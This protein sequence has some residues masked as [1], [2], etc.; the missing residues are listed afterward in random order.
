MALSVEDVRW[1]AHLSRLELP[2]IDLER[3]AEQL[4]AIIDYVNLLQEV[5]T[6]G[7]EPMAHPLP[8]QNVFRDDVLAA[9]LPTDT[10]LANAPDRHGDFYSRT[11]ALTSIAG[12]ARLPQVTIPL[13]DVSGV[14]VGLSLIA[15]YGEDLWLLEVARQFAAN[16]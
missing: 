1:V 7:V 12:N 3:M 14:P 6:D 5:N 15:A 4:S 10:A 11:L 16:R 8:V 2:P 13:A 9:S